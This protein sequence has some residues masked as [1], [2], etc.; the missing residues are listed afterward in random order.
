MVF[1]KIDW[2]GAALFSI[3]KQLLI[4]RTLLYHMTKPERRFTIY[5]L[6][7]DICWIILYKNVQDK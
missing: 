7:D 2:K 4:I 3:Q 5:Y 6:I 1:M